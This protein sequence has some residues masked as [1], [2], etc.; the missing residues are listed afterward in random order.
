VPIVPCPNCRESVEIEPNWYGRR[1]VCPSCE[2]R[3][4]AKR[5]LDDREDDDD[6]P[7][8]R[9][10][11]DDRPKSG[12]KGLLIVLGVVGG[13]LLLVCGG[14][15]GFIVYVNKAKVT[16]DGPWSDQS[17]GPDEGTAVSASFPKAAISEPLIDIVGGGN[18]SMIAYS[19]M[20]QDDSVKDA[21]FAVGYVDYPA[22]TAN[23]LDKGYLALRELI[24]ERF[25]ANPLLKPVI[26]KESS[27]TV[28][29]YPAKEVEYAEDDGRFTLRVIHVNDRPRTAA[30]RLVVVLA[31]G[32]GMKDPDKQK[33]LQS[34][35]IGKGK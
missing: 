10:S 7:R 19:N 2:Q 18:G 26:R 31:G 8:R 32:T 35:K 9:R 22:G 3:F 21:V 13:L 34:V 4:L 11:R 33:F 17:V 28:N 1:V 23:P 27:T 5:P 24:A 20:D 25:V 12:G 30:P 29:G 16:F 14:C 15:V 6:Q